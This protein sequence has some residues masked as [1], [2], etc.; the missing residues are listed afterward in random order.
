MWSGTHALLL[1]TVAL[2]IEPVV[3]YKGNYERFEQFFGHEYIDMDLRVR[4]YNR[5]TMVLNGTMFI[6]QPIDDTIVFSSDVFHSR[7]GNQQFQHYPMRLPTSGCCQFIDNIHNEYPEFIGDIGNIPVLGECPVSV[8]SMI[9][10]DKVFPTSVLPDS[11]AA[12]L[13]KLVITGA[14]EEKA[15]I[16]LMISIRLYDDFF[17]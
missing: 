9:I 10:D 7:L 14:I 13:W 2:A 3:C 16:R 8:R 1:V 12:G 5:T 4:K 6:R 17:M 15:V 11:L